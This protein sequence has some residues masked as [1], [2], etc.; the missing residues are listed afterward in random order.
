MAWYT[1]ERERMET[2]NRQMKDRQV[3]ER[4]CRLLWEQEGPAKARVKQTVH[5]D[6][7]R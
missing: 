5:A 4:L 3:L 2:K 7:A 1:Q 6:F